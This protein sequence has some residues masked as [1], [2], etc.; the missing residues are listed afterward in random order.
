MK[1]I[2]LFFFS[3]HILC[4]NIHPSVL[5]VISNKTHFFKTSVHTSASAFI[6]IFSYSEAVSAYCTSV[7]KQKMTKWFIYQFDL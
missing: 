5:L 4:I 2:I 1:S 6:P 3:T 7:V